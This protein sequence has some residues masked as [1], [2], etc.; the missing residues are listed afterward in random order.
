MTSS[1]SGQLTNI[2]W[3]LTQFTIAITVFCHYF[4]FYIKTREE[5]NLPLLQVAFFHLRIH[6]SL[7]HNT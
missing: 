6:D 1:A 4:E 3:L 2:Y 7:V 5:A